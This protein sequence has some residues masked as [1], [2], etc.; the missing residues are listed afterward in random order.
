MDVPRALAIGIGAP[1]ATG[2]LSGMIASKE[3]AKAYWRLFGIAAVA[4]FTTVMVADYLMPKQAAAA[5]AAA[6]C[7]QAMRSV[8]GVTAQL[9][10]YAG[11]V[12]YPGQMTGASGASA[13]YPTSYIVID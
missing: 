7:P 10:R 13:A 2:L 5:A 6:P 3:D 9:G 1:I 8:S 4:G 12:R 11:G